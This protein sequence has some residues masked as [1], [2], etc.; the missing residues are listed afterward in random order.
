VYPRWRENDRGHTTIADSYLKPLFDGYVHNL[1]DGLT[2]AGSP[3]RVLLMKSNGGIVAGE[4][5]AERPINYLVSGPVGGVLGGWHFARLAGCERVMTLDIGGTSCDVSL[6]EHG[7]HARSEDFEVEFGMPAKAPMIDIRTIG[8]GGGSIAWTDAGGLL[9]VGPRSA[10]ASP[11]PACYGKGGTEPTLTDA[12]LVLGRLNA[13]NFCGGEIPLDVGLAEAAIGRLAAELDLDPAQTAHSIIQLANHNMVDALSVI[14]VEQGIDPRDFALVGFG[15]A[16]ALHAA[17]IA[18]IIGIRKVIVPPYPGNTSA[19]GLLTAGLRSD[20]AMTLLVRSDTPG[21]RER[22]NDALVPL[23]ERTLAN[24]RREGYEAEPVVEQRLE[25][26]YFGQN[27]HREILISPEAPLSETDFD[28]AIAAFHRDYET[29]YGYG[30]PAE[31]VEIVGIIVTAIG[32][33]QGPPARFASPEI[34][35]AAE[36]TRSVYFDGHGFADVAIVQRGALEIDVPRAGP[37]IVEEALSTT[38]VP[39]GASVT[40][41]ASQSLIIDV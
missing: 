17:E 13:E 40:L 24:L 10:G 7:E 3:A 18:R 34:G 26:R 11:G 4:A 14:S 32:E 29:F 19:F 28:G 9:R 36:T 41:H 5:A 6:I 8:A 23:R 21:A 15:G 12:N 2:S 22:I 35:G 25:M 33:R 39:P 37:A 1:Q 31:L 16:G 38:V 30:Q 20:L 27:Y